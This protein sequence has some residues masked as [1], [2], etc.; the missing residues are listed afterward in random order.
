MS[1]TA[2]IR[3]SL[4]MVAMSLSSFSAT[5]TPEAPG[6][7][8]LLRKPGAAEYA[9]TTDIVRQRLRGV[10]AVDVEDYG[11][12]V[13]L[14]APVSASVAD[15]ETA[16]GL[17][18]RSYP[19]AFDIDLGGK[20]V[21]YRTADRDRADA[22]P[23][24]FIDD[25]PQG[26]RGLYVVKLVGP[27]RPEWIKGVERVGARILQP[28][29]KDAFLVEASAGLAKMRGSLAYPVVNVMPYHPY[30]KISPDLRGVGAKELQLVVQLDALQDTSAAVVLLRKLDPASTYSPL[31]RGEAF[32]TLTTNREGCLALA[33]LPSVVHMEP[34]RDVVLSD[35]RANQVAAGRI[36]GQN[37]PTNPGEYK[38]WLEGL[39]GGCLSP[40]HLSQEIVEVMDTGLA[41]YPAHQDLNSS[42]DNNGRLKY[43]VAEF[44]LGGGDPDDVAYHGTFVTGLIAG[45]PYQTGSPLADANGFYY[46][47]GIAPGTSFG[48]RRI[49][50]LLGYMP[51]GLNDPAKINQMVANA[52][53]RGARFHNDSWNFDA[54]AYSSAAREFDFLVRDGSGTNSGPLNGFPIFVAAGN[55]TSSNYRVRAPGTAKNVITVGATGLPRVGLAGNCNTSISIRDLPSNSR[56]GIASEPYSRY[57]PDLV[58]P[59]R[60]VTSARADDNAQWDC[61]I[62]ATNSLPTAGGPYMAGH[63]TSF[64][65]A[66][67]TGAGVLF[68]QRRLFD[69]SPN[70]ARPS[71]AL[72]K[73]TIVG[74]AATVQGGWNY[75]LG[76]NLPWEPWFA[77]GWGRLNISRYIEDATP[78]ALQDE[79]HGTQPSLRFVSS[80]GYRN[81]TFSVA[82]PSKEI[83]VVLA[84][85]DYPAAPDAT[86]ARVNELDVYV[87]QGGY[88]YCDGQY[89]GQYTTRS[90]GCWLPDMYNNVKRIRIAPNSFSGTFMVQV[91]AGSVTSKAV[92]GLDTGSPVNQDWALYVYNAISLD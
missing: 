73:A 55:G 2:H 92:P 65:T 37:L 50:S 61:G 32:A 5:A 89:T 76:Q 29:H 80:G 39:C 52:W 33:A 59:G 87:L 90:S 3:V 19:G 67:V 91:V 6:Q 17:T 70:S 54:T 86:I 88:V 49:F 75:V 20:L 84:Y 81:R 18:A 85:T 1:V 64:S 47:M 82:D 66:Q 8:V 79:D 42:P 21:D 23:E 58:A 35:E 45:N 77:Q 12:F 44:G 24:L 34:F 31:A 4:I 7:V 22:A 74:T 71:P 56:Q 69:T 53:S 26:G 41:R 11:P 48:V 62:D 38:L 51:T 25:Y 27:P 63:G 72:L 78:R 10:G 28:L 68:T 15:L 43:E 36:D 46:G 16:A 9:P 60:T 57:K 40:L 14:T 13:L 30:Y 83:V